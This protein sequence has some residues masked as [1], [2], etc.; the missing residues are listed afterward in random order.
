ME[1]NIFIIFLLILINISYFVGSHASP[2][3]MSMYTRSQTGK[4]A[5]LITILCGTF[6]A[7]YIPYTFHWWYGIIEFLFLILIVSNGHDIIVRHPF[8]CGPLLTIAY[9]VGL[10]IYFFF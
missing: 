4:L 1:L 9:L 10:A 6:V 3:N 5:Y 2:T 8:L 7:I